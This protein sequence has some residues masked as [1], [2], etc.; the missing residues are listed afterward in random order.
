MAG[1]CSFTFTVQIWECYQSSHL[2]FHQKHTECISQNFKLLEVEKS[3]W[4]V[5]SVLVRLPLCSH[6][7][8]YL[9]R[10]LQILCE[11][12][13]S[14]FFSSEFVYSLSLNSSLNVVLWAVEFAWKGFHSSSNLKQSLFFVP[15]CI[16]ANGKKKML[17]LQSKLK[18]TSLKK[19]EL[20]LKN[21]VLIKTSGSRGLQNK[22]V[23]FIIS[24]LLKCSHHFGCLSCCDRSG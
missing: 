6:W 14:T 1:G 11:D 22:D 16:Y 21:R 23:D 17:K 8:T 24:H 5:L 10:C 15:R 2:T 13:S 18:V 19:T 9:Q 4:K 20:L 7:V 3:P 12:I